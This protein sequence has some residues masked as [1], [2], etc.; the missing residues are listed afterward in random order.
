MDHFFSNWCLSNQ[1]DF[2]APPVKLIAD[3]LMYLFQDR[4]LQPSIIDEYRSTISDKLG[5]LPINT[6]KDENL[7]S[8]LDRFHEDRP[9]GQRGILTWNLS[10]V[11]RQLTEAPFRLIKEA[12]LKYL[13]FKT[14]FVLALGLGKCRS[15]SHA[16]QEHQTTVRL[17]KVSLYPAPSFLSKNKLVKDGP[18]NVAP[19]VMPAL[20]PTLAKS[21]RS[22][23]LFRALCY[24]LH[25]T[26]AFRQNKELV[27]VSFKK[28]F[29]KDISPAMISS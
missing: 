20:A 21:D 29:D 17:V 2:R 12:S 9:K 25:R 15:E 28:G 19:V 14:V 27:F 13:T 26:S 1:V 4:K 11:L 18:D 3:L 7:T 16:W 23:C 24:F 10:L 6:S 5:N 22:L 8:L